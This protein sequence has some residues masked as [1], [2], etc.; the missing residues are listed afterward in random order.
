MKGM[1]KTIP[2]NFVRKN[3]KDKRYALAPDIRGKED[4]LEFTGNLVISNA[5][6]LNYSSEDSRKHPAMAFA[7][8]CSISVQSFIEILAK[9]HNSK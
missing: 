3:Q 1:L 7:C 2:E 9:S 5:L 6:S 4:F 8:K